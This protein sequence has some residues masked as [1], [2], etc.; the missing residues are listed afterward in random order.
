MGNGSGRDVYRPPSQ[1]LQQ[2][3]LWSNVRTKRGADDGSGA[4]DEHRSKVSVA[5]LADP[6]DVLLSRSL[7]CAAST[8]AT[9]RSGVLI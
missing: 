4:M 7:G 5:A 8:Q 2:P 6:A 1:K 9:L 3:R